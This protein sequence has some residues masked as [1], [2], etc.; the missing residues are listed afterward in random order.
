MGYNASDEID[1][2]IFVFLALLWSFICIKLCYFNIPFSF[3]FQAYL[4]ALQ[5]KAHYGLAIAQA[6]DMG[7][8][9]V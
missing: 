1:C 8:I 9:L 7:V 3:W 2:R 4:G 6:Q 5:M